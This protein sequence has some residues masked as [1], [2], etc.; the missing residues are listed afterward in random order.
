MK[1]NSSKLNL[2]IDL[3]MFIVLMMMA[4]IG[5][6]IKYILI[7]GFKR[8]EVYGRDVELYFWGLDRHQWGTVHLIIGFIMFSLLF[9]HIILHWK[10]V[11][12][13]YRKMLSGKRLRTFFAIVFAIVSILFLAGPLFLKPE[14]SHEI[15]H[16]HL[17]RSYRE[18]PDAEQNTR[19]APVIKAT[20][21]P[22][23]ETPEAPAAPGNRRINREIHTE[24]EIYGSMTLREV[25]IRYHIPEEE[26]AGHLQIPLSA[27]GERLGRLRRAYG[28]QMSELRDYVESKNPGNH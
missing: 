28:F 12:S 1:K 23:G 26:L 18:I 3:F 2:T 17:G 22:S 20:G 9:L 24:L 21:D 5:F 15:T 25:A 11:V 27:T 16:P 6:L 8:N 13:I 7:P 10:Q 14:I 19:G 4:G